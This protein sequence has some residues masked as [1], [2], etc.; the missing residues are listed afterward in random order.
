MLDALE[1]D[2]VDDHRGVE[3]HEQGLHQRRG[4]A[5]DLLRQHDQAPAGGTMGNTGGHDACS[6]E[7]QLKANV[8]MW[9]GSLVPHGRLP[10]GC[11]T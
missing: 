10:P 1:V 5:T 4:S 2:V 6:A 3:N 9:H 7:P 11:L 8:Y